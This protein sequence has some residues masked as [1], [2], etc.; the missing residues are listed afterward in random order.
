MKRK[1][2]SIMDAIVR[3]QIVKKDTANAFYKVINILN[4]VILNIILL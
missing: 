3:N 1:K 4:F 2:S